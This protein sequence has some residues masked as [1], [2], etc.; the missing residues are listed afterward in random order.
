M[1]SE[2]SFRC[3]SNRIFFRFLNNQDR[4]SIEISSADQLIDLL[5]GDDEEV[6]TSLI[7][8]GIPK[9]SRHEDALEEQAKLA[10]LNKIEGWIKTENAIVADPIEFISL[11][12]TLCAVL[13]NARTTEM[14]TSVVQKFTKLALLW[15]KVTKSCRL[16]DP[17]LTTEHVTSLLSKLTKSKSPH[18]ALQGVCGRFLLAMVQCSPTRLFVDTE[19]I[20]AFNAFVRA[21]AKG[22][23]R[24]N[25][26]EFL[27]LFPVPFLAQLEW[28][29]SP[30][31]FTCSKIS[32]LIV[33]IQKNRLV[34]KVDLNDF[35]AVARSSAGDKHA[36]DMEETVIKLGGAL[37]RSKVVLT[38]EFNQWLHEVATRDGS[39][40]GV[41]TRPIR[42]AKDL[43][44][45]MAKAQVTA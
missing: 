25:G 45:S 33:R 42:L 1:K 36:K 24:G 6:P 43:I 8:G 38:P 19:V 44:A 3:R 34:A 9:V 11:G 5:A 14:S 18:I 35:V 39:G 12:D 7:R 30:R 17:H 13:L 22:T 40:K 28:P 29:A 21:W 32:E 15:L 2:N 10:E 31:H 41:P 37:S 26:F 23:Y 16:V 27:S 4:M 20:S